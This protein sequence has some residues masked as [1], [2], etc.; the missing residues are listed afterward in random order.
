MNILF[1]KEYVEFLLKHNGGTGNIGKYYV[2]MWSLEDIIDFYDECIETGLEELVV[3]ASDGCEMGY[4]F[5]K[6]NNSTRND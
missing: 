3:F 1:S 5:D 2:D 6:K 4:V